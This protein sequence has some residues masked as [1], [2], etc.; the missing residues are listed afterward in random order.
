[1]CSVLPPPNSCSVIAV[2]PAYHEFTKYAPET[3]ATLSRQL[4]WSQQPSPFKTYPIGHSLELKS[5]LSSPAANPGDGERF[6]QRLSRLLHLS[7]GVTAIVPSERPIILRSAPSAGGLYPAEL[8]VLSQGNPGLPKGIYNYQALDHALLKYWDE[9]N[10]STLLSACFVH[11]LLATAKV[12]LVLTAVFQRSAWRYED[13]AYRR[14]CLDIGHLLGNVELA[15]NMTGF[16]ASLIGEFQ[17]AS[18]ERLLSLDEQQEG[19]LAVLPLQDLLVSPSLQR[20]RLE[21]A[22]IDGDGTYEQPTIQPKRGEWL[23]VL[24]QHTRI[25]PE[26][27]TPQRTWKVCPSL[28]NTP[29]RSEPEGSDNPIDKY[30]FPFCDRIETQTV[31]ISWGEMLQPLANTIMHRRSTRQFTG[32]NIDIEH[33]RQLLDFAYQTEH[34]R[35]QGLDPQPDFL[36]T[37]MIETFVVANGIDGLDDGCYYYAARAQQLRQIRFK[38]F[39]RDIHYLCLGQDLGRDAAA[40]IVHT[41][42]LKQAVQYYGDRGYRYL[43]MDAG[44]LGQ[45][46]NLAAVRLQLGVSG[47]AGFFDNL[48]N[49]VLGIPSEE[50]VLYITTVGQPRRL[51]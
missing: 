39:R 5:Y 32:G 3:L 42:D 33:L 40:A 46:I 27:T 48:V 50:A 10:W 21:L 15:A 8:Y 23:Q 11:P 22:G 2:S 36:A 43:H 45:R 49:E 17:D 16:R 44:H 34:Y 41:A 47:V 14:L 51:V 4:D 1:M 25:S 37:S 30:N 35:A 12:A 31:P 28:P 13:R 19:T 29:D 26:V 6:L 7:Y 9:C 20:Y 38:S 24:H 18:I